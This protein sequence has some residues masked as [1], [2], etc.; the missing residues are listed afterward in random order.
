MSHSIQNHASEF[1]IHPLPFGLTILILAD[2]LEMASSGV[3]NRSSTSGTLG[4]SLFIS[5]FVGTSSPHCKGVP[6]GSLPST[7]ST[8]RPPSAAYLATVLP[9]GPPPM[10][11]ASQ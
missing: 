7:T 8:L 3:L 1:E 9:A 4:H 6:I 5:S 2:V 11:M 10:T